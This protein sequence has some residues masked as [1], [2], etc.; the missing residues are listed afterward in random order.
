MIAK[1]LLPNENAEID[2]TKYDEDRGGVCSSA[3]LVGAHVLPMLR[4][5]APPP[6]RERL[7][8]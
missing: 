8:A 5:L 6:M 4:R 1:V 2:E 7:R 3:G